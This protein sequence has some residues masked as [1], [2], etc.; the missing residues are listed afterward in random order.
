MNNLNDTNLVENVTNFIYS[1]KDNKI[2]FDKY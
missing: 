1:V 2:T